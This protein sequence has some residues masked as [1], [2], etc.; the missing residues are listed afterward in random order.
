MEIFLSTELS[1][2]TLGNLGRCPGALEAIFLLDL[3][4]ADGKYLED[5]VFTPGGREKAS[6]FQFPRERPTL[7]NW[8][9]WFNFWLRKLAEINTPDMEMIL[10]SR[11]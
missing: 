1:P 4:T 2:D 11:H 5:F 6:M 10:Q 8:D 3:T 7:C 9:L